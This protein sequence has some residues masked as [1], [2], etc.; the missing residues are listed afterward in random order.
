[1]QIVIAIRAHRC[2]TIGAMHILLNGTPC[3]CPDDITL[4]QLLESHGYAN[5]RVAVEINRQIVPRSLHATTRIA[6]NDQIE[7]VHAMGGG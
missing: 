5:R 4:A 7:I 2:A 6:P 1:L 3:D